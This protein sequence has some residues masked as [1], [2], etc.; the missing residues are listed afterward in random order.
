P[1]LNARGAFP[2]GGSDP[3]CDVRRDLLALGGAPH[4]SGGSLTGPAHPRGERLSLRVTPSGRPDGAQQLGLR[5]RARPGCSAAGPA[6]FFRRSLI[7][8]VST[9][10]LP[11]SPWRL[12]P[13]PLRGHSPPA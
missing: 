3:G 11:P 13:V 4:G 5:E 2:A 8:S 6:L 10:P 12:P 1:S 9:S 7:S